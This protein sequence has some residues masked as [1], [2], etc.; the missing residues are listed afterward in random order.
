MSSK[1]KKILFVGS[2]RKTAKDGSVGGQMF[3]S[4]TIINSSLSDYVEWTLIDTTSDSNILTGLHIRMWKAFLRLIQFSYRIVFFKHEIVFIFVAD[5][6]SF[7]EKGLMSL[8]AKYLSNSK[9][10]LAPRSGIIINDINKGKSLYKF[11][12]FVFRKT[13]IVVCQSKY[14]KELFQNCVPDVP[15]ARFVIIENMIDISLYGNLPVRDTKNNETVTILFNAWVK[16]DKG[17]F[18]FVEAIKLLRQDN[19]NFKAIVAGNGADFLQ[20]KDEINASGLDNYIDLKG[21]VLDNKKIELLAESDIYVLPTYF[22]GF[23]NSLLEAMAAG[24]AC[25]GTR[26]GAIPD[27]IEDNFSGLLIDKQN[28]IQLYEALKALIADSRKR[29]NM[30]VNARERIRRTN[31]L[32]KTVDK[33]KLLFSLNNKV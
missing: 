17:I 33:Y 28:H 16:R 25:I 30:A 26:V 18:E 1:K 27:M 19:L 23:P 10:I 14:W 24:K 8:I 2:F 20:V 11:I 12:Q 21:W 32:E 7:W 9:V 29:Y 5:G 22:D 3:A 13:D 6:W 31:T 4:K 15:G